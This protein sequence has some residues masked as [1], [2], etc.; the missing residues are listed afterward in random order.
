MN[1]DPSEGPKPDTI[2][3]AA[4]IDRARRCALPGARSLLSYA[5]ALILL[6][7]LVA[8]SMQYADPDLWGHVRFGQTM[9][10]TGH[11]IRADIFSYSAL[12]RPWINHEWLSEIVMALAY[13]A[14]GVAGLKLLKF[15][16]AGAVVLL[17]AAGLAETGASIA[18]QFIALARLGSD[19]A[20][21][22][23]AVPAA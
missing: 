2:V 9:L 13:N 5:P 16:S 20:D 18:A 17:F 7:A 4:P 12:G 3:G 1:E 14:L 19:R 22:A 15:L 11:L 6:L 10:N 8:D 21:S 23:D